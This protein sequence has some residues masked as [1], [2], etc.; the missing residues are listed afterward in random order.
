MGTCIPEALFRGNDSL[1]SNQRCVQSVTLI[2]DGEC[3]STK[4]PQNRVD[5]VQFKELR[6]LDWRG[7]HRYTDFQSVEK[8]IRSYG[9]QIQSLTLDLLTWLRAEKIWSDGFFQQNP[10]IRATPDNFFS[11]RVL[12]V[13]PH[14]KK[15]LFS[16]LKHL[17]LS[18]V[19]FEH[20]GMEMAYAF[21]VGQLKSL[22]LRNCP[23]GLNWLRVILKTPMKL[24]S[25]EFALDLNSLQR[26]AYLHITET[27]CNFL[28]HVPDLESLYLALPE[29]I[30]WI[31]LTDRLTDHH[32]LKRIV[33]HHLVDRGGQSLIDGDIPWPFPLECI[34]QE[35]QL[36][37]FGSSIPLDV[38][39]RIDRES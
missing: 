28:Q 35:K 3:G 16:S 21:N 37:C 20:T 8:C 1:L 26:D 24:R 18:A 33:I 10:E 15:I 23:G 29:P 13:Q 4:R 32:R 9:H 25:F 27:V 5:L 6:S 36:S 39:V 19:S 30:N 12:N 17:H 34:L 2:T 14:D 11:Q 7:L 38:L 31:A 22:K